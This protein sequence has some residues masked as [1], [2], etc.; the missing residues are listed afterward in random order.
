[1]RWNACITLMKE[2]P[3]FNSL[4]LGFFTSIVHAF[5]RHLN[6]ILIHFYSLLLLESVLK[7]LAPLS[8]ILRK[9][10]IWIL[11]QFNWLVAAWCGIWIWGIS[12]QINNSFISSLFCLLVL[13]FHIAPSRVF[14]EYVS[15]RRFRWYIF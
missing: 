12:E 2:L 9:P 14:F 7:F 10:V 5:C 15:C 11:L 3:I 13:Y 6:I 4:W 1:M 8:R